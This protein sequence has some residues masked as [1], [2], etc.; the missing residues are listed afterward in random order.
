MGN[1]FSAAVNSGTAGTCAVIKFVCTYLYNL[2]VASTL[3]HMRWLGCNH[4]H[5]LAYSSGSQTLRPALIL[6]LG[7]LAFV[8]SNTKN[9][10]HNTLYLCLKLYVYMM[11]KQ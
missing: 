4:F 8:N 1:T 9:E 6:G 7:H 11:E 3:F 2:S 5:S 10:Q